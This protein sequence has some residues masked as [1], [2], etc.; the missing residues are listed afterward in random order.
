M[1]V[2][3]LAVNLTMTLRFTFVGK[4][5]S[6]ANRTE[7]LPKERLTRRRCCEQ[8]EVLR[9]LIPEN[10]YAILLGG[11]CPVFPQQS[12][13]DR[14]EVSLSNEVLIDVAIL[15]GKK[16]LSFIRALTLPL[17]WFPLHF[18]FQACYHQEFT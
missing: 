15:L 7:C 12:R 8:P 6:G 14:C 4:N 3:R 11:K 18:W 1:A 10:Y 16:E 9:N 17:A 5:F 2:L 13:F